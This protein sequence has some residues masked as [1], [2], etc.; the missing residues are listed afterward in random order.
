MTAGL[1]T[2]TAEAV[3]VD[4]T[5]SVWLWCLGAADPFELL[6]DRCRVLVNDEPVA[7]GWAGTAGAVAAFL[8][9][10]P[11]ARVTMAIDPAGRVIRVAFTAAGRPAPGVPG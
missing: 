2:L 11:A 1:E 10:H 5:G 9:A 4:T 3:L 7:A 6:R 8:A